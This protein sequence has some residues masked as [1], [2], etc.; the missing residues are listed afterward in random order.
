[1]RAIDH[2]DSG[3]THAATATLTL[4]DAPVTTAYSVPILHFSGDSVGIES[5]VPLN[6]VVSC[7]APN[8]VVPQMPEQIVETVTAIPQE[9]IAERI[10][11]IPVAPAEEQ[12][13]FQ[14]TYSALS[15]VIE[16]VTPSPVVE[17][18]A[19]APSVTHVTPS[20]QFSP[21]PQETAEVVQIG[22][23]H[24][25][26]PMTVVERSASHVEFATPVHQEQIASEQT[27]NLLIPHIQEQI[28]EGVIEIPQEHLSELI[29]EQI[30]DTL[31]PPTME[32]IVETVQIIQERFQQSIEEQIVDAPVPQAMEEQVVA[33]MPT[34]ATSDMDAWCGEHEFIE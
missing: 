3:A 26:D 4:V 33:V 12:T 8:P 15:P 6:N 16:Y 11:D 22:F 24:P 21:F 5:C 1:M 19:P 9:W 18:T 31:V 28:V 14:V 10:V 20:E 25:P 34:I 32:K 29:E 13:V 30:V 27:V 23:V 7:L 2:G 17:F